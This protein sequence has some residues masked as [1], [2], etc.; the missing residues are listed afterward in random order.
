[1]A[2]DGSPVPVRIEFGGRSEGCIFS[3]CLH[4]AFKRSYSAAIFSLRLSETE[5]VD[6]G[7][8]TTGFPPVLQSK[9][10]AH[11]PGRGTHSIA[12]SKS[13]A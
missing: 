12:A 7:I 10:P 11:L 9:K 2:P 5:A 6:A 1:M 8:K 13:P 3:D 4:R